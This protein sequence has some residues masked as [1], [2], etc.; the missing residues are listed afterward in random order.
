M[1]NST[2]L[3]GPIVTSEIKTKYLVFFLHGWG[4]DGNDLIQLAQYWKKDL[5]EMTFLAPNAPSECSAN[6]SG[7]QWFDINTEITSQS[8]KELHSSYEMLNNYINS[9]LE[10]NNLN[11]IDYFLVG[12]SQGTMLSIYYA[13]RKKCLGIVGYSGAFVKHTIPKDTKKND[14]LLVHG[15]NDIVVPEE[16]MYEAEKLLVSMSNKVETLSY[17][18]LEH[19]INEEGLQ[20]GMEFIKNKI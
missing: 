3:N 7:R 12:F 2:K 6:P 5:K 10:I 9:H 8:I 18:N 11:K 1:I 14:Y 15:K 16:K 20:K 19:S 13:L 4:S 17:N